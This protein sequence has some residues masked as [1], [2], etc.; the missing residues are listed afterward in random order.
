M[1]IKT[2]NIIMSTTSE[3]SELLING[4]IRDLA[5]LKFKA[6]NYCKQ[7]E[8]NKLRHWFGRSYVALSYISDHTFL[9]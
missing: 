4:T 2:T 8:P 1:V 5:G 7:Y 6:F 3:M 9:S